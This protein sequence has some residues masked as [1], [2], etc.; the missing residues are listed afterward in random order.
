[1]K[2]ITKEDK[3]K[4]GVWVEKFINSYGEKRWVVHYIQ[5]GIEYKTGKFYTKKEALNSEEYGSKLLR[6]SLTNKEGC[7]FGTITAET[8]RKAINI[9]KRNYFGKFI[10][11]NDYYY[12]EISAV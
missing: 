3:I 6:F 11:Q 12:K 9:V 4:K 10:I 5:Y 2:S 1:M 8:I 7:Y